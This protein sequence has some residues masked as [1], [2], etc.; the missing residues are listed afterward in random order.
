VFAEERSGELRTIQILLP[1]RRLV[2]KHERRR[3]VARDLGGNS[4]VFSDIGEVKPRDA[5]RRFLYAGIQKP[6]SGTLKAG[7]LKERR[8]RQFVSL[9]SRVSGCAMLKAE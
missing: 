8:S 1:L 6:A 2:K 7:T 3:G 5:T 4:L 9:T